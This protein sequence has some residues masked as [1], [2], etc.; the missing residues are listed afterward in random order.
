MGKDSSGRGGGWLLFDE[1]GERK[2]T[3]NKKFQIVESCNSYLW[4]ESHWL[5]Y[6]SHDF[7][8]FVVHRTILIIGLLIC[9]EL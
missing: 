4:Y 7:E 3:R 1:I 6:E 9:I 8:S 2:A 5:M